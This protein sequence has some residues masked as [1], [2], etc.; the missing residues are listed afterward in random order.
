MKIISAAKTSVF[1]LL[2]IV[3]LYGCKKDDNPVITKSDSYKGDITKIVFTP[4]ANYSPFQTFTEKT[5]SV[6]TYSNK[7]IE[8]IIPADVSLSYSGKYELNT[9][10]GALLSYK[11]S[12]G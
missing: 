4:P 6:K 2:A 5:I 10:T 12:G 11:K 7:S 9:T 1:S 8:V 3:L